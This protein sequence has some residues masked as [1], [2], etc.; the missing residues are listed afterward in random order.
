MTESEQMVF[1]REIAV[2]FV[3]LFAGD[4]DTLSVELVGSFFAQIHG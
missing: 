1:A 4:E 3:R 2:C